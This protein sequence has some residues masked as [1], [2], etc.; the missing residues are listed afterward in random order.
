MVKNSTNR[1]LKEDSKLESIPRQNLVVYEKICQKASKMISDKRPIM[2]T[3]IINIIIREK[4]KGKYY[5]DLILWC[6]YNIKKGK[7]IVC[8]D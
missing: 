6:N 2:Y 4:L 7:F 1:F 5:I 3:D 8:I